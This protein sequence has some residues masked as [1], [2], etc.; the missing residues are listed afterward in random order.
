MT[1][2]LESRTKKNNISL[3]SRS[4]TLIKQMLSFYKKDEYQKNHYEGLIFI[5]KI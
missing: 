2:I 3:V 1:I 4:K 5:A